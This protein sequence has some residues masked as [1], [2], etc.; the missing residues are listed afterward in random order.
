MIESMSK[1]AITVREEVT[2]PELLGQRML[3]R[4]T[5]VRHEETAYTDVHPDI[6]EEGYAR[7]RAKGQA[8]AREGRIPDAVGASPKTR[9][10]GTAEA[11][12]KGVEDVLGKPLKTSVMSV[13]N[14]EATRYR[15]KSFP[16]E[17]A[18][19]WGTAQ[20]I[21]KRAHYHEQQFYDNPNRI[22]TNEEKR[23]RLYD[24]LEWSAQWLSEH[25]RPGQV[26]HFPYFTHYEIVTL[27]LDD[28]FGIQ[29]V[30]GVSKPEFGEHVDLDVYEPD[31]NGDIPMRVAYGE[32]VAEVVFDKGLR[33]IV[34]PP[35][36][37]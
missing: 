7:M 22:E 29:K 2:Q 9:T 15:D 1:G 31:E 10:Q 4:F 14:L 24:Q 30:G 16:S 21:W 20:D 3:A 19:K 5:L 11:F 25:E 13:P 33:R 12:L 26:L 18:A 28:V 36:K 35:T 34:A 6:T 37:K 32:H 23:S 17:L 27:L 8:F